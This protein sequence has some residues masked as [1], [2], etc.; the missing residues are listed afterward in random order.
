M[1]M[2]GGGN[3]MPM[4]EEMLSAV[5][6][7]LGQANRLGQQSGSPVAAGL[8]PILSAMVGRGAMKRQQSAQGQAMEQMMDLT[9]GGQQAREILDLMTNPA[10]PDAGRD[11][12]SAMYG[13]MI[14]N[15]GVAAGGGA[16]PAGG[17]GSAG[18][19]PASSPGGGGGSEDVTPALW[20][21]GQDD[22]AR[23]IREGPN[24]QIRGL[25]ED[26]FRQK[27]GSEWASGS[28]GDEAPPAPSPAAMTTPPKAPETPL[29]TPQAGEERA[30]PLGIR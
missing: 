11:Q 9:G 21:L 29:S 30:D 28:G 15:S 3:S 18:T 13:D 26:I 20:N 1:K 6:S 14:S 25:A 19:T 2:G 23:I 17:G 4:T 22:L 12:L 27:Y 16:A 7:S 10:L 8:T 5:K 24:A